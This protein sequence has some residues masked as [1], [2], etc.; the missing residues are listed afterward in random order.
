MSRGDGVDQTARVACD[1]I[2]AVRIQRRRSP[3]HDFVVDHAEIDAIREV[4]GGRGR[5]LV[6]V[7][8]AGG[9]EN[10]PGG[11]ERR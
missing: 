6:E 1:G 11:I 10:E 3:R 2:G 4:G 5:E 9:R 8:S 7:D